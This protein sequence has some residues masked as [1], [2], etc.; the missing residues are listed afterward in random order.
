MK[1]WRLRILQKSKA[2]FMEG[3]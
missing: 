3:S 1:I 2:S